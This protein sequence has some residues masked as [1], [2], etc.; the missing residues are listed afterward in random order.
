M[1]KKLQLAVKLRKLSM[2]KHKNTF[3]P[4]E[5]V[6]TR[7]IELSLDYEIGSQEYKEAMNKLY[8]W[9][10]ICHKAAND[11]VTHRFI[12][13]CS[14][15]LLYFTQDVKESLINIENT[16]FSEI[17][18]PSED[19]NDLN[20]DKLNAKKR[21]E[22]LKNKKYGA[23]FKIEKNENVLADNNV[24]E[25]GILNTSNQNSTYRLISEHYLG[26][27]I[28]SAILTALNQSVS[29]KFSND[30]AKIKK[31]DIS[32]P[33]YKKDIPIPI[34]KGCIYNIN[35]KDEGKDYS[36]TLFNNDRYKIKFNTRFGID[37]SG[38][39]T[40][41][42]RYLSGEY[43]LCGSSISIQNKYFKEDSES[44]LATQELSKR[45]KKTKI[46][47]FATFKFNQKPFE[48]NR[49]IEINC[50]LNYEHPIVF[51]FKGKRMKNDFGYIGTKDEFLHRR[52]AIQGAI[53]RMQIASKYNKSGKGINKKIASIEI[54]KEKEK[55][56]VKSRMHKYSKELINICL[57]N[58]VGIINLL[59]VK[60]GEYLANKNAGLN[61]YQ[62]DER[63]KKADFV[64]RNWSY[65]GLADMIK[66][67][68][69]MY[70]IEVIS[71]SDKE[72]T[73]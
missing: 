60:E 21:K 34:D 53:K 1:C 10:N 56:Y 3:K 49:N 15:E 37:K 71:D 8:H 64:I 52:L 20:N 31:G 36:F 72:E 17:L 73:E 69:N 38:N 67:K 40:I 47:L 29:S 39:K 41:W 68:A 11:I 46:F 55:E 63:D 30:I 19:D 62:K 43:S 61:K 13:Q 12:Q 2:K 27:G 54:F 16:P 22:F 59:G 26:E 24:N 4:K 9:R 65:Y 44:I 33:S 45:K 58:N 48:A 25:N 18:N 42:D 32:I 35:K 23:L 57:S 50:S 5:V 51:D 70:G 66:Y 14:R 6:I 28:P 7:R